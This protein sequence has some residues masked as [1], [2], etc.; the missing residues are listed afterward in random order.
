MA[1]KKRKTKKRG[2]RGPYK[3]RASHVARNHGAR[4]PEVEFMN[5]SLRWGRERQSLYQTITN[6]FRR[7]QQLESQI[8]Q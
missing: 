5:A 2:K 3:P 7:I 4:D 8:A 1:K 6:Q